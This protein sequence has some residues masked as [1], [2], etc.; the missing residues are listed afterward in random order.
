MTKR[1]VQ[2]KRGRAPSLRA[3]PVRAITSGPV[4]VWASPSRWL[5]REMA[6]VALLGLAVAG[7]LA[8]TKLMNNQ[9]Y[10]AGLGD[11]ET[12]NSSAYSLL[13]GVPV[14]FFGGASFLAI[15][16]LSLARVFLDDGWAFL[17]T[18]GILT[19]TVAG[20]IFSLFLTYLEFFVLNATCPWCLTS[21]GLTI[22]LL[23][24][25]VAVVRRQLRAPRGQP[26]RK[27]ART[28]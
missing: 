24:L 9:L 15:L 26:A 27:T 1:S 3:V 20:T 10:C 18:L 13:F 5:S 23:A 28:I 7:Y 4:A 11:C 6:V 12:V 22:L 14:S 19:L 16:G 2:V 25:S 8:Y 21:A 17:A